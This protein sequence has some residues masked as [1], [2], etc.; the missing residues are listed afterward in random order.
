MTS[1][2]FCCTIEFGTSSTRPTCPNMTER[3]FSIALVC[4]ASKLSTERTKTRREIQHW[5]CG[6]YCP[7]LPTRTFAAGL[8]TPMAFSIVAPS[9]VTCIESPLPMLCRI[10][11]C[12]E[13]RITSNKI[14]S[15]FT[16]TKTKLCVKSNVR[17]TI[18]F[19]P[20]VLF[21]KSPIA[22]APTK[23][24]WN[25]INM[26]DTQKPEWFCG[27]N[28]P[29]CSGVFDL[30]KRAVSAFSSSAPALNTWT[31]ANDTC[32]K[33]RS[34][35]RCF[36]ALSWPDLSSDNPI[37]FFTS[38][39]F[40]KRPDQG[41]F[42]QNLDQNCWHLWHHH[43][44]DRRRSTEIHQFPMDLDLQ[45]NSRTFQRFSGWAEF[46]DNSCNCGSGHLCEVTCTES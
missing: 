13:N 46:F 9:F 12:E 7:D 25:Q 27:W 24:D 40:E 3:S 45:A 16:H 29:V 15:L 8:S 28:K 11:S 41:Q 31:G 34:R 2:S 17:H 18:P 20:S 32:N 23:D 35:W 43:W 6:V 38:N 14:K 39:H 19:G 5:V 36:H 44:T 26:T 42:F 4:R 37:S 21:T 30:T 33:V 1:Q 10:L 22:I